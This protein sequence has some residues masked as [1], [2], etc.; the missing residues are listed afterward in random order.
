MKESLYNFSSKLDTFEGERSL[1]YNKYLEHEATGVSQHWPGT[2]RHIITP[3]RQT[4]LNPEW[5]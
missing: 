3:E 4:L 1:L 5:E 2:P